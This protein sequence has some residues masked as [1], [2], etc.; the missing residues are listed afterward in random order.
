M[1]LYFKYAIFVDVF[2]RRLHS[3]IGETRW[4]WKHDQWWQRT[5]TEDL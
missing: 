2:K 1:Y 3:N 4:Q 5:T